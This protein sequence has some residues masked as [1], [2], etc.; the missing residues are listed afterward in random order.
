M[1]LC[2]V[3]SLSVLSSVI[4]CSSCILYVTGDLLYIFL[5]CY[6]YYYYYYYV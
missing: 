6:Y 3:P 1:N 5:H 4:L 2:L